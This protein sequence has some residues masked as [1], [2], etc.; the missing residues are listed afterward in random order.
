VT[1]DT[2]INGWRVECG[3]EFWWTC[4][5]SLAMKSRI[6]IESKS[7]ETQQSQGEAYQLSHTGWLPAICMNNFIS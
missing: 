4:I 7:H 6:R 2:V 3:T 1:L 5:L